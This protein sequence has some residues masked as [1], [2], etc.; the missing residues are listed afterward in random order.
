MGDMQMNEV[1][2]GSLIANELNQKALTWPQKAASIVIVDQSS[3]D[4]AGE[5]LVGIAGLKKE[6]IAYNAEPKKLTHQAWKSVCERERNGLDPLET[7]EKTLKGNMGRFIQIER[8][9]Q[10]AAQ[11]KADEEARRVEEEN[12]LKLAAEAEKFGAPEETISEILEAPLPIVAPIVAPSVAPVVGVS[13]GSKKVYKWRLV[14]EH[15][16]P[17]EFLK[18]DEVKINAYVRNFTPGFSKPLAGIEII[19]DVPRVSVRTKR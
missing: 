18:V 5:M 4:A 3:Y 1:V 2:T 6:I 7:A 14:S 15:M 12:R 17:R 9:K 16:I 13:T 11:R 10:A 8:E 19:E